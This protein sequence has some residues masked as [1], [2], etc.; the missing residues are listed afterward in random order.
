MKRRFLALAG[1]ASVAFVLPMLV[2]SEA[3]AFEFGTRGEQHPYRSPQNFA[4]ELR[5]GPYKPQVDQDPALGG[6]TPFADTFG[7]ARIL[8]S[9]EFDWQMF[10][11]PHLGTIGPGIGVGFTTMSEDVLTVSGRQSGDTTSLDITPIYG[12][13]VLRADVLWREMNFPFVPYGK[14][15]L[16]YALWR[17]TNTGGTS[18]FNG[19][20]GKGASW[21]TQLALGLAFA[22]DWFDKGAGRNMD[23]A[24]GINNSYVFAEY[25]WLSL[26]GFGSS[27]TLRVG[28]ATWTAGLAFEF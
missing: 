26:N 2:T 5:V 21:G 15:G 16:G 1:V 22:L 18:E 12:V 27:D 19:V 9:L 3:S 7:G 28:S 8:P 20:K 14:A 25:Y 10:R 6:R 23:N 4:L 24:T 11:I 13:A 17:A